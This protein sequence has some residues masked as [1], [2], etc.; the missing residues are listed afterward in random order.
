MRPPT[1]PPE[2][3]PGGE[4]VARLVEAGAFPFDGTHRDF[5]PPADWPLPPL[6]A[7]P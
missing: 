1:T 6:P 5:A 3:V 2:H 7:R 4:A